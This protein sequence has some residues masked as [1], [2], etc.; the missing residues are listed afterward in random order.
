MAVYWFVYDYG[1]TRSRSSTLKAAAV[2]ECEQR[3][4]AKLF[5]VTEPVLYGDIVV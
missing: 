1:S 4:E 3:R 5:L 2:S